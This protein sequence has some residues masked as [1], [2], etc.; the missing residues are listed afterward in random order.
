LREAATSRKGVN[1]GVA[2]TGRQRTLIGQSSLTS[3]NSDKGVPV[4]VVLRGDGLE[5]DELG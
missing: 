1:V 3:E 4:W 5:Y 2:V